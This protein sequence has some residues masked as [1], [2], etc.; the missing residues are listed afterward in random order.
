MKRKLVV[1]IAA[2]AGLAL[3]TAGC[4]SGTSTS[5]SGTSGKVISS[6][7]SSG[8]SSS[9]LKWDKST[10]SYVS[11]STH[12]TTWKPETKQS[13]SSFTIGF[14]EQDNIEPVNI[15][16]NESMTSA[17]KAAGATLALGNNQFPSTSAPLDAA[18]TIVTRHP[19]VVINNNQTAA[20][21]SSVDQIFKTA[22]VPVVQVV[23][24]STGTVLFGPSNSGM[25][26]LEGQRLVAV[27]KKHGWDP[28]SI[29]LMTTLYSPAGAAVD[30]RAQ[31]C[32]KTVKAAFPSAKEATS[33]TNSTTSSVL[34]SDFTD[35]LTA[36]PNAKHILVCTVADLWATA[37]ANA[38][39]LAGKQKD[40]AVT[41]INGGT[42]ILAA[43][44][45][46][47]TALVG[48][49]DL[50]A[51]EWGK[52]WVPMAETIAA[53]EPIPA[54]VDAPIKMLPATY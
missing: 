30:L 16:M 6:V 40:A 33:D 17:T 22:C 11:A 5:S 39:K 4:S 12:P 52:Y 7:A 23:T 47:N 9:W 3:V 34:Q 25:G 15:S 19:A 13:D 38:L 54:Q 48:T 1:G 51:A 43:I 44:K 36:N 50:G 32:A 24:A 27:A 18:R 31:T 26:N 28:S 29:T 21:L 53:G 42:D 14:G 2:M 45:A 35:Q 41:G 37:D 10:C 46:G 20:L 8:N 49:V